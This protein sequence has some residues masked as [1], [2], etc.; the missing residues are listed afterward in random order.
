MLQLWIAESISKLPSR[1]AEDANRMQLA[2][3]LASARHREAYGD[4]LESFFAACN[5]RSGLA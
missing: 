1:V 3:G 5:R 2:E 4:I